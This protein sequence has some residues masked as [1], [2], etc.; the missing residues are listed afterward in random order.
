MKIGI[1]DDEAADRQTLTQYVE[2]Y[3]EEALMDD[4]TL[5]LYDSGEALLR[6]TALPDLLFLDIFMKEA[7]GMDTAEKL[8]ARGYTGGIVF[9]TTSSAF[10]A[11]SY[12]VDALDYL[13]KPFSYERFIKAMA[14]C[15][16]LLRESLAFITVPSGRQCEHLPLKELLYVETG[17]HCLLFHTKRDT[18]KSPMTMAEAQAALAAHPS[19]IRCHRSY[20]VNL[21]EVE[22]MNETSVLLTSGDSVLLN[23]KNAASLKRQ[24]AD[25]VWR[26]MEARHG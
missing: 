7:T 20:I 6:E 2:R 22:D 23:V 14:K 15:R 11:D 3:I 4:M 17:S 25:Y 13:V 8:R 1:C 18:I 24:I 9:T 26:G 21:N 10:G 16:N 5:R 19:F 12:E